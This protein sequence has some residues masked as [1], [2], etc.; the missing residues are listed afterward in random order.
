MANFHEGTS[1]IQASRYSRRES[2]FLWI[3]LYHSEQKS[4][5]RRGRATYPKPTQIKAHTIEAQ[6]PMAP[7][8]SNQRLQ[9]DLLFKPAI[10]NLNIDAKLQTLIP[11]SELTWIQNDKR[12]FEFIKTEL[13][14]AFG[15]IAPIEDLLTDLN[16]RDQAIL[17]IDIPLFARKYKIRNIRKVKDQWFDHL[18]QSKMLDWFESDKDRKIAALNDHL[19]KAH[20]PETRG[21]ASIRN[22]NDIEILYDKLA[23]DNKAHIFEKALLA[24][25]RLHQKRTYSERNADKK[26]CNVMLPAD[27]IQK[28]DRKA[29]KRNIKRSQLIFEI[30]EEASRK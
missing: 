7:F 16:Y 25:K 14:S 27:L 28:L 12:Q 13:Y 2:L 23:L 26:Q 29:A 15:V 19:E 9:E 30:L 4:L 10:I 18:D 6:R 20:Y 17:Q 22:T 21:T 8:P 5:N 1:S 3:A 11:D 24:A